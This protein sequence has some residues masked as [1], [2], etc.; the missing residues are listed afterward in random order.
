MYLALW[1][2]EA[3]HIPAVAEAKQR[4]DYLQEHGETAYVFTFKRTFPPAKDAA[5][6]F[7][8]LPLRPCPAA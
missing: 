7:I 2:V 6:D 5:E 3:G 8:R 1:W 4:L